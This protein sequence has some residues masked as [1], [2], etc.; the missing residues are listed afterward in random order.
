MALS[1]HWTR[2]Q[3]RAVCRR[4]LLDPSGTWW[5]DNELNSY[6]ETAQD[7]IQTE[8]ELVYGT[9]ST[10]IS[11][12][13]VHVSDLAS[14]ML[15]FD[16]LFWN[17]QRLTP[18]SVYEMDALDRDWR[19]N[20][21][22]GPG[23][24]VILDEDTFQLWPPPDSGVLYMEYPVI[25]TFATDTSTMQLPAWTRYAL[26]EYVSYRAYLKDGPNNN[27]NKA[28]RYKARFEQAKLD[29]KSTWASYFPTRQIALRP[30]GKYEYDILLAR[31]KE[32]DMAVITIPSIT[33]PE[34]AEEIPS[35]TVNGSNPTFTLTNSPSPTSSLKV[36]V[37]GLLMK[38]TT[39]YNISGSTIT[40]VSSFIP[41]TGQLL[42]A[43]YRYIA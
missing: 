25:T 27:L 33:L 9:S 26:P 1:D 22:A 36:W 24:A 12:N 21:N 3:I 15:R 28:A 7:I 32:S 20:T 4:E 38:Q 2:L 31:R 39:H 29:I 14:D 19:L 11:T 6:I 18:R 10:T 30:A 17:N 5:T 40:F 41:T 13:T 37:D 8:H 34:H 43:S 42:F 35:G 16:R 23:V